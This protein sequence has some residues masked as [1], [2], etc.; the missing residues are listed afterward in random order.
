VKRGV[1][2]AHLR[3]VGQQPADHLERV[4]RGRL[5]ERREVDQRVQLPEH[6]GVDQ[7]RIDQVAATVDDAVADGIDVAA[8]LELRAERRLVGVPG[9]ERNVGRMVQ[10]VALVEQ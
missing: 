4:K 5:M 3:D 2:A 10:V 9:L 7:G 8:P 1:K 6:R